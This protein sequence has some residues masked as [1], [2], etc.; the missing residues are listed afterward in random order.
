VIGRIGIQFDPLS[1]A[2]ITNINRPGNLI[3]WMGQLVQTSWDFS[4]HFGN[5][6]DPDPYVFGPPGSG[7]FYHQAKIVRKALIF[8]IFTVL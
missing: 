8:M 2:D 3:F 5:F 6:A 1:T 7:S 4:Y